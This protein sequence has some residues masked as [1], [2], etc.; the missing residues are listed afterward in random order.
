ML[1]SSLSQDHQSLNCQH[2]QTTVFFLLQNFNSH[3]ISSKVYSSVTLPFKMKF[4][5]AA[6]LLISTALAAPSSS[7]PVAKRCNGAN[8]PTLAQVLSSLKDWYSDVTAVNS[9]VDSVS[10]ISG[11]S[12]RAGAQEALVNATDEPKQ[13]GL[14]K[15]LCGLDDSYYDAIMT[16]EE[17]FP[18]VLNGL[19]IVVNNANSPIFSQAGVSAIN[20]ARCCSVLPAL[21]TVWSLAAQDYGV[22]GLDMVHTDV[23]RP[24]VCAKTTC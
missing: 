24:D 6:T 5:Y 20:F 7:P 1:F 9:F 21:D 11:N 19:N 8:G 12:L 15:Q 16:L 14:L 10:T 23:P 13:L 4:L 17:I 3:S 22:F 2:P 18:N